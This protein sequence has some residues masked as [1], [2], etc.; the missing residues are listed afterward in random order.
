[1]KIT[2]GRAIEKP[3]SG[4]SS[5]KEPKASGIQYPGNFNTTLVD[6]ILIIQSLG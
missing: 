5:K 2:G 1:M 4:T 6:P 3:I